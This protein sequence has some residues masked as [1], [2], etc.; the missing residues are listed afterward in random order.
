M[1]KNTGTITTQMA[2]SALN[3]TVDHIEN[4]IRKNIFKVYDIAL[5]GAKRPNYRIEKISFDTWFE[6]RKVDFSQTPVRYSEDN[7]R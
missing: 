3:C 4:L 5:P 1:A 2:A 7:G 6:N